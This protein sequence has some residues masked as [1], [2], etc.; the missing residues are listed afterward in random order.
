VSLDD[1]TGCSLNSVS[2]LAVTGCSIAHEFLLGVWKELL[3]W[4]QIQLSCV[5][6]SWLRMVCLSLLTN[7]FMFSHYS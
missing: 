6:Q 2:L 5:H 1:Y 4:A 3:C 7:T